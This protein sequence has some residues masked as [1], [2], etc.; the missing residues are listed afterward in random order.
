MHLRRAICVAFRLV[1]ATVCGTMCDDVR[2]T[3][4]TC[5]RSSVAR[6]CL[7]GGGDWPRVVWSENAKMLLL[8]RFDERFVDYRE[9]SGENCETNVEE[10]MRLLL[11]V[12]F[13][14]D[15]VIN[16]C[17]IFCTPLVWR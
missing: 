3:L 8:L 2:D 5:S 9:E 7:W 16:T 10:R 4:T 13:P 1:D 14:R 6:R 15:D 12:R 11:T 17:N